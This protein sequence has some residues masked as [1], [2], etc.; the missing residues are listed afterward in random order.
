MITAQ[1]TKKKIS[2]YQI[3]DIKQIFLDVLKKISS[4]IILLE[5]GNNFLNIGLAKS[6]KNNL[7]IKKVFRQ[8]LPE[9]ALE[10]SIPSDPKNFGFFLKQVL[11]ENK[12][13]TSRVALLLPSDA[14]YTRLIE[15]PEEVKEEDSTSFLENP[16]S[17]I[18]IPISLE[19]SDFDIKITNLPK[20]ELQNKNFNKYFLTSLP[21]KNVDIILDSLKN[22]NLEI[23][24]IQMS[25]NCI[26]NLLKPAIDK[27]DENE[28]IIS[29]DLLDEFTQFVIFDCSGPLLIKRLAAIR[30]YP[31]IEEIK[32]LNTSNSNKVK[33]TKTQNKSE[34]YHALSK[35]DLKIL[36]KE[37]NDSFNN[38]LKNNNLNK[39]GKIF[40]S[41]R[42]SQHKNLVE[43]IG[44]SLKMDVA[45]IS[46]INTN[47][48]KEFSYDPDLINQFSMSRL[49]G[50]GLTLV[51]N[52]DFED[53]SLSERF[54]VKE[55]LYKKEINDDVQEIIY[56]DSKKSEDNTINDLMASL[57]VLSQEN[58]KIKEKEE[59]K[60]K[61]EEKKKEL[62][63][64]P[65][66]KIKEKAESKIKSEEKKKETK[67]NKLFKVDKSFLKED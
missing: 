16:D 27:L 67:N 14:C 65:N 41:G 19:N 2:E 39:K 56:K 7:Y 18:Q 44:K 23:C 43:L 34:T 30:K 17:G 33:N 45:L 8:D 58:T 66:L 22:A 36:L 63:P 52:N 15:I 28:L 38:F 25:H 55:F 20:K 21:K 4:K 31:S 26:A 32:K 5:I 61:S 3:E 51:K 10:K 24:S 46:P 37:I 40:L 13:N 47:C 42:N 62:P 53:E 1:N 49:I 6:Q 57:D 59:S 48:L 54:V 64:L 11:D 50:L 60:I 12:I 9:E 35:L 29:V